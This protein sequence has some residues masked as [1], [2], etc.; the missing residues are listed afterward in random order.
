MEAWVG[1]SEAMKDG[2]GPLG[3]QRTEGRSSEATAASRKETR[4]EPG[5]GMLRV[6]VQPITQLAGPRRPNS[7]PVLGWRLPAAP[8]SQD[9]HKD[10]TR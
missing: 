8:A 6:P 5:T 3:A 9:G 10:H 1:V 7:P 2:A 4:E